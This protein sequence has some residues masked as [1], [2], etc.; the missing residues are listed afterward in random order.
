MELNQVV[1]DLMPIAN[2]LRRCEGITEDILELFLDFLFGRLECVL[3][4]VDPTSNFRTTRSTRD[5]GIV[6][7]SFTFTFSDQRIAA[8]LAAAKFYRD[9]NRV[10]ESMPLRL[11]VGPIICPR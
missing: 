9:L 1:I 10:H 6:S 5:K 8:A 7:G 2:Q 3:P 4:N 11:Q